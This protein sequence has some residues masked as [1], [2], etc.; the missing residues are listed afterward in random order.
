MVEITELMSTRPPIPS[1]NSYQSVQQR[2]SV[3]I[4]LPPP[5][6]PS[7][8]PEVR[9]SMK[10]NR[11]S[12]VWEHF[13]KSVDEAGIKWGK[14]NN[15]EGGK[16]RAGGKKYGT[17]NLNWHLTKCRKYMESLEAAQLDSLSSFCCNEW[18]CGHK[19][20]QGWLHCSDYELQSSRWWIWY[21]IEW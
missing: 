11:T 21:G 10:R 20:L 19:V 6:P 1:Q 5:P 4:S 12:S 8:Q 17:S 2:V 3:V 15:C 7:S 13:Q 18:S 14:C 16:Y 9:E